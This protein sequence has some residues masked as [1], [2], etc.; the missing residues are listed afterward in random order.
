MT[1]DRH[2]LDCD[3]R[4]L[5]SLYAEN[6]RWESLI[7]ALEQ[8][9]QAT[10]DAQELMKILTM[11][12]ATW[13]VRVFQPDQALSAYGRI[14]LLDPLHER[15]FS[16]VEK[17]QVTKQD[18]AALQELYRERLNNT[19]DEAERNRLFHR[20]AQL[21]EQQLG[22]Q[23]QA[24]EV[25]KRAL[26]ERP[27]DD[28]A[29]LELERLSALL[30]NWNEL[31]DWGNGFV[32]RLKGEADQETMLFRLAGWYAKLNRADYAVTTLNHLLQLHPDHRGALETLAQ[33]Y[34]A[35]GEWSLLGQVLV[36][37]AAQDMAE[38]ERALLYIELAEVYEKQLRHISY[39]VS[40]YDK[41]LAIDGSLSSAREALTRIYRNS[42]SWPELA[43]LLHRTAIHAGSQRARVEQLREVANIYENELHDLPRAQEIN[44]E[45]WALD[46]RSLPV[47][48]DLWR[49]YEAGQNWEKLRDVLTQFLES[50]TSEREGMTARLRLALL[51]EEHFGRLDEAIAQ[52]EMV[53][54]TDGTSREALDQLAQLY[55][56][57]ERWTEL[58]QTHLRQHGGAQSKAERIEALVAAASVFHYRAEDYEAASDAYFGILDLD[59][60]HQPTLRALAELFQKTG[61][62]S[63]VNDALTVLV[64]LVKEQKEKSLIF[65]RLGHNL[66][67]NLGDD[68]E[69]YE[70]F[71]KALD[72]WKENRIALRGMREISIKRNDWLGAA[73]ALEKESKLE[74][75]PQELASLLWTLGQI[76]DQHLEE[77]ERAIA[78]YYEAFSQD[79]HN[80]EAAGAVVDALVE[81]GQWEYASELLEMVV[82]QGEG[83]LP[84]GAHRL[85]FLV[86]EVARALKQRDKA[87]TAYRA[88]YEEQP[89]DVTTIRRLVELHSEEEN[90][91]QTRRLA[92]Q[93]VTIYRSQLT[94]VQLLESLFDLAKAS[95]HVGERRKA[96]GRFEEILELD[97]RH[98]GALTQ[99]IEL[100]RQ[101]NQ[102]QEVVKYHR[103]L[104]SAR[105]STEA[106]TLLAEEG[107]LLSQQLHDYPAA[108]AAYSAAAETQP[109]DRSLWLRL[110]D[111]YRATN[112]WQ[113]V[114]DAL[115]KLVDLEDGP[116]QRAAYLYAI[117]LV[118]RD[119]LYELDVA[120]GYFNK[121]LDDNPSQE[122]ALS[123]IEKALT[124]SE[125]WQQ[126]ANNYRQMLKRLNGQDQN[127]RLCDLSDR[128]AT[129]YLER[130]DNLEEAGKVLRA[131]V[132]LEPQNLQRRA[133][134]ANVYGG[135][136]STWDK[137][138]REH[139]R[140]LA[141]EPRRLES[142]HALVNLYRQAK[143]ID[144]AWCVCG[145]LEFL[146]QS[147]PEEQE[148]FRQ[149]RPPG[150]IRPSGQVGSGG[151]VALVAGDG[152][153]ALLNKL[154]ATL[155]PFLARAPRFRLVPPR[156]KRLRKKSRLDEADTSLAVELF[157]HLA[158]LLHLQRPEL[159]RGDDD[160]ASV[161]YAQS[162]PPATV[163][164]PLALA[165]VDEPT[166]AFEIGR[167]LWFYRS[168]YYLTRLV[169]ETAELREI[170]SGAITAV[171]RG[172]PSSAG[173]DDQEVA[174]ILARAMPPVAKEQLAQV[175]KQ[176]VRRG[177][178]VDL[179]AWRRAAELTA[180][181]AGLLCC[182]S[183]PHAVAAMRRCPQLRGVELSDVVHDMVSFNM[184]EEH[185]QLR[186]QLDAQLGPRPK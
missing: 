139:R 165:S 169:A 49:D 64:D 142:L 82:P 170:V 22:R 185:F 11:I 16:A 14:L 173:D 152:A 136:S 129:L 112:Q 150:A 67:D 174:A 176:L 40:C 161:D 3:L 7:E 164:S 20:Q 44:E 57:H 103:T 56:K 162:D 119:H 91:G 62:W 13:E 154:F 51:E 121:A 35:N 95:V 107:D 163:V 38:P 79:P 120:L 72:C 115:Q 47:M 87:F 100:S 130:L 148:L 140:L 5:E 151:A 53:L 77:H 104:R 84:A 186:R 55:G 99:L 68:N 171:Q 137:A 159:Y 158:Q 177:G 17:L 156:R 33:L 63:G 8:R 144:E 36:H 88:A 31:V 125:N 132:R 124:A 122:K 4:A 111:C 48:R 58:G 74:S 80:L 45:A 66:A 128:L 106:A 60:N 85:Q 131:A 114:A 113:A 181:R 175:V 28:V 143:R 180:C 135:H 75:D 172:F 52:L 34:R 141:N 134:L 78:C 96:I 46:P 93:L 26:T 179:T 73:N 183:L 76:R 138:V 37:W 126:L 69:A 123:A 50:V 101:R 117:A 2:R 9:A 21:C 98:E 153:T 59:E 86:G 70:H 146:A 102:W 25:L 27:N 105:P 6:S 97:P 32:Q 19:H 184:S 65:S 147:T 155:I 12:A 89:G 167:H 149:Y 18:L 54:A 71:R 109:G 118:Y 116:P 15:A 182:Q 145:T 110:V 157:V 29:A 61:D 42:Q 83:P 178:E 108:I 160:G 92:Q 41:A 94:R 168:E 90:W 10:D 127:E 1:A 166:L 24:Y 39:A 133:L 30:D 23:D 81:K 43:E